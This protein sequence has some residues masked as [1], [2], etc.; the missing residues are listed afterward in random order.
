M[1]CKYCNGLDEGMPY[2]KNFAD[3]AGEDE[4]QICRNKNIYY[5]SAYCDLRGRTNDLSN[6]WVQAFSKIIN[7]CPMCGRRLSHE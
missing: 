7:Y 1:K 2:G 6:Q 5:I 3:P 4:I